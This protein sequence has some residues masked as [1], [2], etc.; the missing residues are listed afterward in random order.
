MYL[1]DWSLATAPILFG[2]GLAGRRTEDQV[3]RHA[4]DGEHDPGADEGEGG[5][6]R[7]VATAPQRADQEEKR[8]QHRQPVGGSPPPGEHRGEEAAE[9]GQVDQRNQGEGR[10]QGVLGGSVERRHTS[11]AAIGPPPITRSP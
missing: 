6:A 2:A 10:K 4:E 1:S 5:S 3:Q 9:T 11:P 7:E 8:A